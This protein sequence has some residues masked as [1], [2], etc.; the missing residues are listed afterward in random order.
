MKFI[1]TLLGFPILIWAYIQYPKLNQFDWKWL[2][3]AFFIYCVLLLRFLTDIV[4]SPRQYGF[5]KSRSGS[6][7]MDSGGSDFYDND[8]GGG[9]CGGGD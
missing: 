2:V 9:D 1:I 6:G 5:S 4:K 7:G 3:L 8:A